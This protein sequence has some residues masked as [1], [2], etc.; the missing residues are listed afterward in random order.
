MYVNIS[1]YEFEI[2]GAYTKYCDNKINLDPI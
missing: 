2:T 1:Q